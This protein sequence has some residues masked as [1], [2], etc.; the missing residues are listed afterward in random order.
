M[1]IPDFGG[2]ISDMAANDVS[3]DGTILVGTG[4][5]QTGPVG[6]RADT[7][8]VDEDLVCRSRFS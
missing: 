1:A 3:A 2:G 4:N 8:V 6:W 7:A 5:V